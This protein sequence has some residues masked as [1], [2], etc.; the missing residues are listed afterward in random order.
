MKNIGNPIMSVGQTI[1]ALELAVAL[2][3]LAAFGKY[4]LTVTALGEMLVNEPRRPN[5][6][7]SR[8][9]LISSFNLHSDR[10]GMNFFTPSQINSAISR[11]NQRLALKMLPLVINNMK[12]AILKTTC[13][14]IIYNSLTFI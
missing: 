1:L 5:K 10:K 8:I 4:R 12:A 11:K 2:R 7:L 13:P 9:T 14:N 6:A 3:Y